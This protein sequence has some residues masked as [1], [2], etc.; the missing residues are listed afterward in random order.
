MEYSD[1]PWAGNHL[2]DPQ[3]LL[4]EADTLDVKARIRRR[5]ANR[6]RNIAGD[7]EMSANRMEEVARNYRKWAEEK[8]SPK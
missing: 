4:H 8:E 1:K 2:G 5:E 7:K 6:L 3:Q